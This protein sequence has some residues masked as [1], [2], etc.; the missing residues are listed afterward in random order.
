MESSRSSRRQWLAGLLR[1]GA[2]SVLAAVTA[3]LIRRPGGDSNRRCTQRLPC[4]RCGSLADCPL[5]QAVAGRW[6]AQ[7]YRIQNRR[8]Y[9]SDEAKRQL[10]QF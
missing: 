9:D 7:A 10:R 8:T 5:P 2:V 6:R 1:W 3:M 4:E